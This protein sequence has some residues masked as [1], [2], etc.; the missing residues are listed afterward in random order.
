MTRHVR[1]SGC[2]T[3]RGRSA[4]VLPSAAEG[5]ESCPRRSTAYHGVRALG[6]APLRRDA[7]KVASGGETPRT[8][9]GRDF[10]NFRKHAGMLWFSRLRSPQRYCYPVSDAKFSSCC[11]KL[12]PGSNRLLLKRVTPVQGL[13]PADPAKNCFAGIT[14][15]AGCCLKKVPAAI[16][17]VPVHPC[18]VSGSMSQS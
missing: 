10:A 2:D 6:K 5:F 12:L 18:P 3:D 7:R 16:P 4:P 1:C 14:K 8:Q 15:I 17:T 11:M 13:L 9:I